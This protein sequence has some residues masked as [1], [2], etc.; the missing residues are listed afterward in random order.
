MNDMHLSHLWRSLT[1]SKTDAPNEDVNIYIYD[2]MSF[3]QEFF[4]IYIYMNQNDVR[5]LAPPFKTLQISLK[6]KASVFS[7]FNHKDQLSFCQLN[8]SI[9]YT[10]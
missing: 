6:F 4:I 1:V 9:F 3:L 5:R 7:S 2:L 8:Q 10:Y